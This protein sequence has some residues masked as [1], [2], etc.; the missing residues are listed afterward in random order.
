[1]TTHSNSNPRVGGKYLTFVL[2]AE[3]YGIRI[4]HVHEIIALMP[5]TRVPRTPDVV[6]GVLNLRGRIVPVF[7][8]HKKMGMK[9]AETT[10]HTCIIVVSVAD[11][12]VGIVVDSVREVINIADE[13]VQPA[14]SFGTDVSTDHLLGIAT[15]SGGARLLLAIERVLTSR[16]VMLVHGADRTPS[17]AQPAGQTAEG[18]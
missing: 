16:E 6:L 12:K 11:A 10:R 14:P 18:A 13:Q 8:M 15:T 3:E 4:E 9:G 2:G 1:M 17:V 5:V 7:D